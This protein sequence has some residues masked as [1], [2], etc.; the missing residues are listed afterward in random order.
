MAMTGQ[1]ECGVCEDAFSSA[2]KCAFHLCSQHALTDVPLVQVNATTWNRDSHS[3]F[4]AEDTNEHQH[5]RLIVPVCKEP[6]R[7]FRN[8]SGKVSVK[9]TQSHL[10]RGERLESL[11]AQL[12]RCLSS[13]V[14]ESTPRSANSSK[15]GPSRCV[16]D[17]GCQLQE[18]DV[19]QF[20]RY[21]ATVA[22]VCLTG[23]AQIPKLSAVED[24]DDAVM[25]P[26]F[27]CRPGSELPTKQVLERRESIPRCRICLGD[28]LDETPGVEE[29]PMIQ[30][31]CHCKGSNGIMHISCLERWLATRCGLE[32][33]CGDGQYFSFNPPCC[34]VCKTELPV[35]VSVNA[36]L[37][38]EQVSLLSA[39]PCIAPPFI[40]LS[41][42]RSEARPFGER[43][44]F[45]PSQ[46]DTELKIG[47]SHDAQLRVKDVSVSR[48]HA[49][50]TLTNGAF[51][52]KDNSSKFQTVVRP[53]KSQIRLPPIKACKLD[54]LHTA[55][56]VQ[57]GRT[58]LDMMLLS[59]LG[60]GR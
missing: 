55:S 51:V 24:C 5:Q 12:A 6:M 46:N 16:D 7:F 20:G 11:H 39:L 17:H 49:T 10:P 45:A 59:P 32:D 13:P 47:R 8:T 2:E 48:L 21:K 23:E 29:S 33:R 43:F 15:R 42:P 36:G 3:L 31:P 9:L 4:N 19:I 44:V 52:L 40:V 37:E 56:K 35:A 30:A 57:L 28:A 27:A 26:S 22:Q 54:H 50:V 25:A 60:K 34:E 38:T 14:I 53:A 1:F 58:V 41:M 18:G